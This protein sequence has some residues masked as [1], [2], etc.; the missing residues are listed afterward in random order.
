MIGHDHTFVKV[1]FRVK[2]FDSQPH[3]VRHTA[4]IVEYHFAIY[5][6]PENRAHILHADRDKI[7]PWT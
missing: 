2:V 1:V 4:D 6:G 5:D 3:L 7:P